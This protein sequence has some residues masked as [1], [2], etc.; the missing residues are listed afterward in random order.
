MDGYKHEYTNIKYICEQ[1]GADHMRTPLGV[2]TL[3][4]GQ[5]SLASL[6]SSSISLL[7]RPPDNIP[8]TVPDTL[9]SREDL[10]RYGAVV[11]TNIGPPPSFDPPQPP[12]RPKC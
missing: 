7:P 10:V 12:D 9:P 4:L 3:S 8:R 5:Q 11:D 6:A 1:P 2:S